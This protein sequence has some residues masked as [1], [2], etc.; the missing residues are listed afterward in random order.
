MRGVV[1]FDNF[2][3]VSEENAIET[4]YLRDLEKATIK[5]LPTLGEFDDFVGISPDRTKLLYRYWD[6]DTLRLALTDAG[7]KPLTDFDNRLTGGS[8]DY[9]NWQNNE[10]IRAVQQELALEIVIPGLYNPFTQEYKNL[11]TDWPDVHF[12][13]KPDDWEVDGPAISLGT[14]KGA[15]IVYDPSITRVVYPKNKGFVSLTDVATGEEL[16]RAHF[17]GWGKDPRWSPDGEN[18]VLIARVKDDSTRHSDEFFIV[19][20]DGGEFKR[21]TY[22]TNIFEEMTIVKYAWSPNGEQIVFLFNPDTVFNTQYTQLEDIELQS[23]VALLDI[24]TGAITTLCFPSISVRTY[25][26]GGAGAINFTDSA[27]ICG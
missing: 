4:I 1:V 10:N 12:G 22:L 24:K 6:K 7:G 5:I 21:L 3:S 2:V 14:Y 15:N 9:Y 16:A 23:E 13:E 17:R 8:W 20:R 18:L 25:L 27:G 11:R 26:Y 19:S